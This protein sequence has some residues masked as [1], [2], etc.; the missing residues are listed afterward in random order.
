MTRVHPFL[1]LCVVLMSSSACKKIVEVEDTLPEEVRYCSFEDALLGN[2]VS[3]AVEI[4]SLIDTIDSTL[5]DG[6]PTLI[7]RMRAACGDDTLLYLFYDTY[8]GVRTDVLRSTN[9]ASSAHA[10]FAFDA[11][12]QTKDTA[13]ATFRGGYAWLGDTVLLLSLR[14]QPNAVTATTTRIW[15]RKE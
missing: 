7:Y 3:E 9:F 10:I 8:A 12:E 14:D 5:V 11:L 2:W 1:I 6:N 13:Q 15:F 4:T